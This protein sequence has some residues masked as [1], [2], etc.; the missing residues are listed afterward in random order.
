MHHDGPLPAG[1]GRRSGRTVAPTVNLSTP[2]RSSSLTICERKKRATRPR[3]PWGWAVCTPDRSQN[4]LQ[5]VHAIEIGRTLHSGEL[6]G[7]RPTST[8]LIHPPVR[9]GH[10]Q[11][12]PLGPHRVRVNHSVR[13]PGHPGGRAT[14]ARPSRHP[15]GAACTNIAQVTGH[16]RPCPVPCGVQAWEQDCGQRRA[17][18]CRHRGAPRW[19]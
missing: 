14:G 12:S 6:S 7:R 1:S 3:K 19:S 15:I 17:E 16:Q 11:R 10:A 13:R 9:A 4:R 8:I 2:P 18:W 5:C